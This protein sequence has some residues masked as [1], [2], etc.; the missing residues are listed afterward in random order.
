MRRLVAGVLMGVCGLVQGQD[1]G[2]GPF[3]SG[4]GR[5]G[6]I[7]QRSLPYQLSIEHTA[8]ARAAVLKALDELKKARDSFA[9]PGFNYD[10]I[11]QQ[12]QGIE[13]GIEPV[14]MAEQRRLRYQTLKP[15]PFF[16][17][18][19]PSAIVESERR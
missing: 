4:Y 18:K 17:Q 10:Q 2:D 6:L 15:D 13:K 11:N 14:L 3:G 16:L 1:P 9:L 19:S 12:L 5:P 8:Q 7:D